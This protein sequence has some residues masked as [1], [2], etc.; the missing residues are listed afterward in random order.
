MPEAALAGDRLAVLV[1][2]T[3][4]EPRE[5]R[6]SA[7]RGRERGPSGLFRR[8]SRVR[9]AAACGRG[10]VTWQEDRY[11]FSCSEASIVHH[12]AASLGLEAAHTPLDAT[13]TKKDV[14][15]A[16]AVLRLA[17]SM[18]STN[19]GHAIRTSYLLDRH[20]GLRRAESGMTLPHTSSSVFSIVTCT[21]KGPQ[22]TDSG[23]RTERF[24]T[25]SKDD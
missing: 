12:C 22:W 2:A 8:E 5:R 11:I 15:A 17:G 25:A 10:V 16:L 1:T 4:K 7:G 18:A 6:P 3:T 20:W 14:I 24:E 23:W 9:G 19:E 21:S 13:D